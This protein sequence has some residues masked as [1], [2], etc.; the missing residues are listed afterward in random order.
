MKL[1]VAWCSA[2]AGEFRFFLILSIIVVLVPATVR[3]WFSVCYFFL[4]L[5]SRF[6]E[7]ISLGKVFLMICICINYLLSRC[8]VERDMGRSLESD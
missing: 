5:R 8:S 3:E 6:Q 4:V 1:T 7:N 2:A